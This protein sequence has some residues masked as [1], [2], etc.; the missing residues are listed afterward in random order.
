MP[1]NDL[2]LWLG[3]AVALAAAAS[4]EFSYVLQALEA[5]A[6]PREQAMRAA[7]LLRLVRRPRWLFAI[8]LGAFG[9]GLQVVAL[10]LAPLTLVQPVIASGLVLLLYLGHR[11]LGEPVTRAQIA[12]AA[13]IIVGVVGI[14]LAAPEHTE[15]TAGGLELA[16]VLAALGVVTLLPYGLKPLL[17][18]S[19]V[20]LVASAGAGDAWAAFAAKLVSDE[21]ADGA[22]LAAA[23]FGAGAGLAVLVGLTSE[24]SALQR[25]PIARVAPVILVLQ[26]IVPV[27][28]APILVGEDWGDTPLGGAVIVGSLALV[29]VSTVVLASARAVDSVLKSAGGEPEHEPGR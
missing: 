25:L 13:A 4:F 17:G 15:S 12:A 27:I 7:L 22:L 29:I 9:W 24:T 11:I 28:L 14:A 26:T 5:R 8:L 3:L 16:I 23:A 2:E 21:L 20:L 19:G 18:V 10:G 6:A 1:V